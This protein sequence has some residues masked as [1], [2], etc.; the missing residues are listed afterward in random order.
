MSE[1]SAL[2]GRW[3]LGG[4]RRTSEAEGQSAAGAAVVVSI[5]VRWKEREEVR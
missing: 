4:A 2:V 5:L 3:S 1:E